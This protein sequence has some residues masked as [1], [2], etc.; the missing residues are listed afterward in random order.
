M[1]NIKKLIIIFFIIIVNTSLYGALS[2]NILNKQNEIS[3][4]K[5]ILDKTTIKQPIRLA[6]M[7]YWEIDKNGNNCHY[8]LIDLLKK[9]GD[10]N[11]VTYTF[12]YWNIGYKQALETNNI[13]GIMGLS[14]TKQRENNDFL[15]TKPYK[16]TPY[17][18]IVKNNSNINTI[19]DLKNRKLYLNKFSPLIQMIK[20]KIPSVKIVD[21]KEEADAIFSFFADY[22]K[23]KET[24]Y[25]VVD[26]IYD[27]YG[28]LSIG[29]N[30]KNIDTFLKIQKAFRLIPKEELLAIADDDKIKFT[31]N[32][33]N[34]LNKNQIIHYTYNPDFKPIEWKNEL[35]EHKG[36]I[37][38]IIKLIE[39]KSNIKFKEHSSKIKDTVMFSAMAKNDDLNLNFTQNSLVSIPYVF[40]SNID[41]NYNNG[42]NDL[43]DKKVGVIKGSPIIKFIQ[44]FRPDIKFIPLD[45]IKTAF[46]ML[47]DNDIDL[48]ITNAITA[49]YYITILQFDDLGISYKTMFN[50][51]LKIAIYKSMPQE[52]LSIL[53]KSIKNITK[54]QL[55]DIVDKWTEIR[56]ENK[57][58]WFFIFQVTG[59][60]LFVLLVVFINN[61]KL[62]SLVNAKTLDIKKQKDEIE[63]T[64]S[65][66]DKNVMFTKTDLDGVITHASD[67]FCKLS[68]YT[69]EE[70]IGQ[71]HNIM[72]YPDTPKEVFH[73]VWKSLKAEIPIVKEF[74]TLKK[75]GAVYWVEVLFS[76]DYDSDG[77]LIGYSGIRQDVTDKKE[78]EDLSANLE[79]KVIDRTKALNEAKKEIE[80]A[81]KNTRDS[82]EY[83]SLIQQAL[84][85]EDEIVKNFFS[86]SFTWWNPKD[87]VGGDIFLFETLRDKNECLFM[88]IDCAGHGVPGAF[89]TMLV[90]A[91]ERELVAK[92]SKSDY[93]IDTSIVMS[94]FNKTM[95]K[96]LHQENDDAIS[97]A[98]F[99]GAIVYINK[100]ENI[101]RFTGAYTE[102]FYMKDDTINTIKGDKQSVGYRQCK[103]DYEYKQHQIN[104]EDGMKF[105]ISTDGYLDQKGGEKG[106]SFG[107]KRFKSAIESN[108]TKSMQEQMDIFVDNLED[109]QQDYFRI[110]DITIF[111]WKV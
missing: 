2:N 56:V 47:D 57:T 67:A 86:D 84:I 64:L 33:S 101:I 72:R 107:K 18:L 83:A 97:N 80:I 4:E 95:K 16:F 37:R 10:L 89:A 69:Q 70:L 68:G 87:I 49:K 54:Q 90:K 60:I 35:D 32:E 6:V 109:Y 102:L 94:H 27:R 36:I 14:W 26:T 105:Y 44:E 74:K 59:I 78:V 12:D 7:S 51:D 100:T 24:N 65:S 110:D 71:S 88:V 66:F 96:L 13:D 25:K 111:G 20:E 3:L 61:Y 45:N 40:V 63:N 23:L 104:I 55:D 21:K 108:Y 103:A 73:T 53:E 5:N 22:K 29:I 62:K 11:I 76:P 85:P 99:D 8:K 43:K 79:I 42:F 106:F 50:L 98:G 31:K 48:I 9:Y 75:N 91:I 92:I 58:D 38:D 17:Y 34:W 28:E 82:I 1:L 41:E 77:K 81:H 93:V 52:L 19:N 15:Y 39:T 30:H 46:N